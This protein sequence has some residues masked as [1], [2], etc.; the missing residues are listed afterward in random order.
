MENANITFLNKIGGKAANFSEMMNV[1]YQDNPIPV[2][3]MA[4]AIPFY[5]YQKHLEDNGRKIETIIDLQPTSPLRVPAD[6]D[7]A[8]T[9][10]KDFDLELE[11]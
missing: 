6:I 5:Y 4:F 1:T 9:E 2:P 8:L 7:R 10:L 11:Y 3:E